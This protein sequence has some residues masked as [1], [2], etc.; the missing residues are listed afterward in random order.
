MGVM[1][2][3]RVVEELRLDEPKRR[4]LA[5]ASCGNAAL[6]AAVVARAAGYPLRVFV[7]PT[8]NE[9][10]VV[11]M[12][13]LGASIESCARPA[14]ARGD[15][16]YAR[17]RQAVG[18]GALPF[19]CQGNENGLTIEGGETLGLEIAEATASNPLDRLFVQVGGGALA[20]ACLHAFADMR[21]RI[22]RFHAVQTRSAFPLK[23]AYDAVVAS[24]TAAGDRSLDGGMQYARAHRNAFMR[25]W[26]A[27]PRS[28]AHGI[29]D[30]ETYDWAAVVDGML[31]SS[32]HPIVVGED[33]LERANA[34]ACAVT[35]ID[36]DHTGSAGLAGAMQLIDGDATAARERIGVIFSGIRRPV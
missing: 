10:I 2:Y 9:H 27:E 34:L 29:L 14:G 33:E 23:R 32:G 25:P 18:D 1:L 17:F 13:E 5:I 8:A 28:V 4:G 22:P 30:D 16:C 19:C 21:L 3:L 7:P 6:A 31:H 12:R 24:V 35:R 36:V 11:R 20:S 26:E 15:P